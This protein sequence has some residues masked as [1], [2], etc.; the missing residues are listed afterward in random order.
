VYPE[1][2]VTLLH[3]RTQLLPKFDQAMHDESA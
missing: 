2:K 3:S 1:K